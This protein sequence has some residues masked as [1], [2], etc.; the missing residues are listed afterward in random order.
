MEQCGPST[1]PSLKP[2]DRAETVLEA[3]KPARQTENQ[4]I[5]L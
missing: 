3:A 4:I 2:F 5:C 1:E